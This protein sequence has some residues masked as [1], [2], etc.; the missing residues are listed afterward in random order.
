M[1]TLAAAPR[2]AL[3]HRSSTGPKRFDTQAWV[4]AGAWRRRRPPS[5]ATGSSGAIQM[6]KVESPSARCSSAQTSRHASLGSKFWRSVKQLL[7]REFSETDWKGRAEVR[8]AR[9]YTN[10]LHLGRAALR[11]LAQSAGKTWDG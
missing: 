10:A 6:S 2:T 3:T 11:T 1:T 9:E 7:L 5:S 4:P 8:P